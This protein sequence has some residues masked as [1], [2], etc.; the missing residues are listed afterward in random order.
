MFQATF[1]ASNR[2]TGA[3][4]VAS[5]LGRAAL[6]RVDRHR[7]A[8]LPYLGHLPMED[9]I[10]AQVG[11][12]QVHPQVDETV[13]RFLGAEPLGP[14]PVDVAEFE[15][16]VRFTLVGAERLTSGHYQESLL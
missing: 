15:R 3:I 6:H 8:P 12:A 13:E 9:V 2:F 4:E 10:V 11:A 5:T 1:M 16:L 7:Q 14:D